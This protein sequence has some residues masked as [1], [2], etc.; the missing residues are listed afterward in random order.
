MLLRG[1]FGRCLHKKGRNARGIPAGSQWQQQ[2]PGP[3]ACEQLPAEGQVP[4]EDF[5]AAEK[6]VSCFRRSV[7]LQAGQRSG[8]AER[9][10]ARKSKDS[11]QCSQR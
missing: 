8:L 3:W 5:T 1:I 4:G 7:P 2:Q 10:F 9:V 6:A 11:P